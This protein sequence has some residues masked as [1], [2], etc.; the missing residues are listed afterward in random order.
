MG[1]FHWGA[2]PV[3]AWW[4]SCPL[5]CLWPQHRIS[6]LATDFTG[7]RTWGV[8][9]HHR[10]HRVNSNIY[11][12]LQVTVEKGSGG[13]GRG[14]RAVG[15]PRGGRVTL[16]LWRLGRMAGSVAA[17]GLDLC[18]GGRQAIVGIWPPYK[19]DQ[20]SPGR[21][22]LCMLSTSASSCSSSLRHHSR[23]GRTSSNTRLNVPV[24]LDWFYNLSKT[25]LLNTGLGFALD[26]I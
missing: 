23:T 9:V 24:I 16:T 5:L 20:W 4:G 18:P 2:L 25:G 14:L 22:P 15:S 8:W 21:G 17:C 11:L 19:Q 13:W 6:T 3:S 12:S 1:Y 10:C 7:G 26:I